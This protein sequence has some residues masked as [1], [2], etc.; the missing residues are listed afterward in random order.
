MRRAIG[1]LVIA[2]GAVAVFAVTRD[3]SPSDRGDDGVDG[4]AARTGGPAAGAWSAVPGRRFDPGIEHHY[5]VQLEHASRANDGASFSLAVEGEWVLA[6]VATGDPAVTTVRAELRDARVRLSDVTSPAPRLSVPYTFTLGERGTLLALQLP[7]ELDDETRS[8]LVALAATAQVTEGGAAATWSAV[9]TDSLGMH[10]VRYRRDADG[11]HRSKLAYRAAGDAPLAVKVVRSTTDIALRDDRWPARLEQREELAVGFDKI[12]VTVAGR[13]SLR[14]VGTEHRVA[15]V[16]AG[17]ETVAVDAR[18]TAARDQDDRELLDGAS[19]GDLLATHA[20]VRDDGNAAAHTYLRLVALFRLDPE[21]A[22]EAGATLLRGSLDPREATAV[23]GALGEAGTPLAQHALVDV[24]AATT[25]AADQRVASALSLGLTATPAPETVAALATASQATDPQLAATA[26]LALGNASLR[27]A[28]TDA[29]GA[30]RQVDELLARLAR[31]SEPSDQVIL[32]RALGN[33]GDPRILPALEAALTAAS[34]PVR[35]AATEALR[36]IPDGRADVL[37]IAALEDPSP[38][39]RGAAVFAASHRR[40]DPVVR[41]L[42]VRVQVD[43]D[44]AVRRAIVELAAQR[45][46]E[47]PGLL[48]P[49]VVYAAEHDRDSE[50]RALARGYL[51]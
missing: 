1:A 49:I 47:L 15:T 23:I 35:T 39:V 13:I 50:L 32:L 16:P 31:A 38:I 21:A 17:L 11:L 14:H 48:R 19:L 12:A 10:D 8:V 30:A 41:A 33:T 40:L 6:V 42:A 27:L 28:G 37:V 46:G 2:A 34:D 20:A 29:A 43:S 44:V 24:V 22:R 51:G 5:A 25:T 3:V 9:E 18:S 4:D 7:R 45:L 26:T 36:L